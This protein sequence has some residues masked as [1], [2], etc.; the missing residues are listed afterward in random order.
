MNNYLVDF[1]NS[2]SQ[3]DINAY[4]LNNQ[5]NIIKEYAAFEKVYLVSSPVTPAVTPI[6]SSVVVDDTSTSINLLTTVPVEK[7]T[8]SAEQT[9]NSADEKDWWKFY[10]IRSVD[11][12][13]EINTVPV[14]GENVNVYLVDSGIDMAHP[15][16][17]GKDITLLYSIDGNFVDTTGH[18][19]A[20]ASV[21]V[22][23]TCGLTNSSLKVVKIFNKDAPT[24]Q[25][26]LLNA[27][28]AI[29][30]DSLSSPNLVS[31]VNM[32]WG[33]PKNE[34]IEN[35]IQAMVTAGLAVVCSAG[36]AGVPITDVTPASMP[37]VMTIG[38]YGQDFLPSDFSN[39]T[40]PTITSLTYNL[41]DYGT[42]DSWAPGE[43][44]WAAVP[45]GGY[46]Y[47]A[48]TS[49]AAAIYS[50]SLAYN[51]SQILT[52]GK[53]M[54]IFRNSNGMI[55]WDELTKRDRNNLLDLTDPK[56][57]TS[58]NRV[59]TFRDMHTGTVNSILPFKL[60][61]RVGQS[62]AVILYHESVTQAYEFLSE[63][64]D[65]AIMERNILR[66]TPTVDSNASG[67]ETL[68][69]NFR[70]YNTD[71]T[72]IDNYIQLVKL[73]SQFNLDEVPEN[74]E[75]LTIVA[76]P[77]TCAWYSYQCS[78]M[79]ASYDSFCVGATKDCWC[80]Y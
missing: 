17:E 30:Q 40:N 35:K 7:V 61:A 21:I 41:T 52:D 16:F 22:G 2:A 25:S 80:T 9:I 29:I 4:F 10:S 36:N 15:E 3:E 74:D 14:F 37:G 42:L 64:P 79:C 76:N 6:V 60:V 43:M 39:Y 33:I 46:G 32:S 26:Q 11:L 54:S 31:I 69:L 51:Q 75:L 48:G 67:V 49:A 62:V 66:Y 12:A 73:G 13:N 70:L 68:N 77:V 27:I 44:I 34:Y 53:L 47:T 50:A 65:G 55:N 20:L 28:E 19:T 59:C 23:K 71:G 78:G 56:Y 45:N 24:L 57:A 58:P 1:I 5:C 63:L 72:T 18:G 38:S 8:P